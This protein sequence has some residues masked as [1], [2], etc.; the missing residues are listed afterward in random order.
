MASILQGKPYKEAINDVFATTSV[1][2]RDIDQKAVQLLDA[3]QKSGKAEAACSHLKTNLEGI[4]REK[5]TN[6]RAYVYSLLRAFDT[7]EYTK[8]KEKSGGN[9][10][11]GGKAKDAMNGSA[12]E[13]VPGQ[14]W[15]GD[16]NSGALASPQV[17]MG[18]PMN[19]MMMQ[20]MMYAPQMAAAAAPPPPPQQAAAAPTAAAEATPAAPATEPKT[21][22]KEAEKPA[23][24]AAPAAAT[25]AR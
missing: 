15:S 13:F 14:W 10:R 22:T 12:V 4:A 5:V 6:W 17:S 25:E 8:M 11:Q 7:E 1:Q 16:A 23:T 21:E 20:Q 3:L 19:A 24:E 9:R 18:Y 2:Q